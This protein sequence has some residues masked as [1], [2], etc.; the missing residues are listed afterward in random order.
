[1]KKTLLILI[2]AL[3]SVLSAC[4]KEQDTLT[5]NEIANHISDVPIIRGGGGDECCHE[6]NMFERQLHW[7]SATTSKVL[8]YYPSA[9]AE[10]LNEFNGP[11]DNTISAEALIGSG[12]GLLTFETAFQIEFKKYLN[13]GD[14]TTDN[15]R[16]TP[17]PVPVGVGP[18][19]P[20]QIY[21]M[22][23]NIML[24]ENCVELYFPDG[25]DLTG[26]F[27]TTATSHPLTSSNSN[28]GILRLYSAFGTGV[29]DPQNGGSLSSFVV[30]DSSY[31]N[32]EGNV[33]VARP[34]RNAS[35][36]P[37]QNVNCDY[38]QYN[39]IVFTDFLD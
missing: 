11:T 1:M 5:E 34:I 29:D 31:L 30:V 36:G 20:Q 24:V 2:V 23:K 22:Y 6:E 28:E 37:G 18:S 9:R 7:L 10:V 14:P 25:L 12:S 33:I 32:H 17:P 16:P 38:T 3:L 15:S 35:S 4:E 8:R 39:G 19:T 26:P 27:T 13:P 21:D